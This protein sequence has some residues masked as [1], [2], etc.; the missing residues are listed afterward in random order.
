MF[1]LEDR[2]SRRFIR[3]EDSY[4]TTLH[5]ISE[6]TVLETSNT[7]TGLNGVDVKL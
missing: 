5:F 1:S 2:K 4:Q 3:M 6:V 7:K